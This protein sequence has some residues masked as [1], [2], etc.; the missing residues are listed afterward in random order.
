M[1]RGN[2]THRHADSHA[3]DAFSCVDAACDEGIAKIRA[4]PCEFAEAT[5]ATEADFRGLLTAFSE[6]TAI[7][8]EDTIEATAFQRMPEAVFSSAAG[9]AVL[10]FRGLLAAIVDVTAGD[11][12]VT[13]E[14]VHA[15]KSSL[16]D[17]TIVDRSVLAA[18]AVSQGDSW[19]RGPGS[20]PCSIPQTTPSASPVSPEKCTTN[21]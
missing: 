4:A 14:G 19:R 16:L 11:T 8:T 17:V 18:E 12:A 21:K 13:T 10:A 20:S 5:V 15:S 7:D 1:I 6:A 9:A 3:V 2:D